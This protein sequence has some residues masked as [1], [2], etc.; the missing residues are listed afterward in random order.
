M[1]QSRVQDEWNFRQTLP[2]R[3]LR[4]RDRDVALFHRLGRVARSP[5]PQ[6]IRLPVQPV[7]RMLAL[8]QQHASRGQVWRWIAIVD[9]RPVADFRKEG[10][11]VAGVRPMDTRYIPPGDEGQGARHNQAPD[12]R[13]LH[14]RIVRCGLPGTA[15]RSKSDAL[16]AQS[17]HTP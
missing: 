2:V 5:P 9:S 15:Q 16:S 3:W 8:C 7:A 10:R 12:D 6:G 11:L 4:H 14:A 17:E 1:F 13:L